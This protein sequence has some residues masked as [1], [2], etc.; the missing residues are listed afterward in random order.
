[1]STDL[2]QSFQID[3][4][5]LPGE[6]VIF[7]CTAAMREIR[8]RIDCVLTSDFPVL[9]QG[10]SGTG[11]EVIARFLHT[12]S[13]RR[14]APF[15][16]LNCAAIPANLLESELFGYEKGS[17]TGAAEARTGLV[18]IA[19]GGTLFLDE[20]GE[21]SWE[22]QGKVLRLLQDGSYTRIGGCE[23]RQ[24]RVRVICATNIDLHN[25][26]ETGA[27]REDLFYRIDIVSLRLSALRDRKNDIP[28]LCD[29]FLHKLA[30][31]FRR[32]ECQL[33][34]ATLH[35]LKQWN[36][37]GNLRELENWI[38][39]AIILGDDEALGAE[40]RRQMELTNALTSLQPRLGPLKEAS[41]RATSS[42]TN[43]I[44][45]KVLQANHWNRRKTAEALNM[46]YRSLLYKLR[47]VGL[48]Q[49]RRGHRG[50]PRAH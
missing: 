49:R 36:W 45:L 7:G 50:F 15:V 17:F 9:I 23:E 40:L 19:D 13:N 46:S 25:A 41:R 32:S 43:A 18:E 10:E 24:G 1:M 28:Q 12:R 33:N 37:P 5:D 29:Y 4:A 47:E 48:P 20:I 16:K 34:P 3:P 35:L 22:L 26:V 38:A 27:F 31:Q 21:L 6:A 8:N 2:K 44:I 30:R 39:R 14:D 42:A 11:K